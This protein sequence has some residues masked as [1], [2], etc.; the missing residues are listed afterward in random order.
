MG[1]LFYILVFLLVFGINLL[2]VSQ[3]NK[4]VKYGLI[5]LGFAILLFMFGFRYNVGT[6]YQRY[7]SRYT[8]S[9]DFT[10]EQIITKYKDPFTTLIWSLFSRVT[11]GGYFVFF[12]YG[13]LLLVP[14]YLACKV[15]D[16]KYLPYV[17][18]TFCFI[19]LPFGMNGM[20]QGAALSFVVLAVVLLTNKRIKSGIA[21]YILACLLH[22]PALIL[23]PYLIT[24]GICKRINKKTLWPNIIIT[25]IIAIVVLFFLGNILS[26]LGLDAYIYIASKISIG[27]ISLLSV[28]AYVP[29]LLAPIILSRERLKD[30][31]E[32]ANLYVQLMYSGFALF[33]IGTAARYLSRLS[34]YFI[35][36]AIPLMP[37]LVQHIEQKKWRIIVGVLFTLYLIAFF[38]FQCII[39]GR[40]EIIPY[41]TYLFGT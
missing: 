40:H 38:V 37:M 4:K 35:V 36:L 39:L 3:K 21:S 32:E 33:V 13:L 29:I 5:L 18:L 19:C 8:L 22:F 9:K 27:S 14:I 12:L 10:F 23:L 17:V 20:R 26:M 28:L 30:L 16:F 34:L 25:T 15:K 11:N 6:D 7:L 31:P 24:Y 2:A 1:G 41:Q